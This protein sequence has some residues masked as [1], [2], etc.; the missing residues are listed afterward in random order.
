MK[1][2]AQLAPRVLE[3]VSE[4]TGVE[5]ATPQKVEIL[6]RVAHEFGGSPHYIP[7]RPQGFVTAFLDRTEGMTVQD[8]V[9]VARG[10]F[11][12]S[13]ATAYRWIGKK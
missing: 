11:G 2:S 9:Q 4:V 6:R 7:V 3:I 8:M 10:E 5:I 12:V 13:R 1:Q